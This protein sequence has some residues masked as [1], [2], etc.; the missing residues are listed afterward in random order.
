VTL[1]YSAATP[2]DLER[3]QAAFERHNY[4]AALETLDRYL[5]TGP[6]EVDALEAQVLRSQCR[7]KLGDWEKGVQ[8]L[9]DLLAA[10]PELD[11]RADLHE[12]L[13]EVGLQQFNYKRL[14]IE[15]YSA[16]AKFRLEAGD[17]QGAAEALLKQAEGYVQFDDWK[18]LRSFDG[19]QP[20]DWSASRRLQRRYAI[21]CLDRAVELVADTDLAAQATFRKGQLHHREL[22]IDDQ[23]VDTAIA[24]FTGL[25]ERWPAAPQAAEALYDL[26]Q[27]YEGFKQDYVKAVEAYQRLVES[28]SKSDFARRA[29]RQIE[30]IVSPVI[31]LYVEGPVLPGPPGRVHYRCR[32]VPTLTLNAYRVDLFDLIRRIDSL[33]DLSK[34]KPSMQ[35]AATWSLTLPDRGEHKFLFSGQDAL[36]P[37]V[38]PASEPGAYVILAQDADRKVRAETMMIVSRLACLTKGARSATLLLAADARSG[39]PAAG[40]EVLLQRRLDRDR[41]EYATGRTDDAGRYRYVNAAD[42]AAGNVG[43]SSLVL[44]RDGEHFAACPSFFSWYWWGYGQPYRAYSFTERPV[45]RP[46]QTVHFKSVLRSY[47]RGA[48]ENAPDRRLEVQVFNP[49]GEVVQKM[50]LQTNAEGSA[51]G[52][53]RLPDGAPLGVYR[54]NVTVDGHNL[55]GDG[56]AVFRIEEYR[57]PE[58]E[59]TVKADRPDCRIGQEVAVRIEARY[60]F[61]EPVA[62]AQV[63]ANVFRSRFRPLFRW[64]GR[65]PWFLEDFAPESGQWYRKTILPPGP[66]SGYEERELVGT[67]NLTTDDR[68]LA[69]IQLETKPFEADPQADLRYDIEAEATDASRR[70]I[71]GSG[72]IKVT[73]AP[74]TISIRPQR[75]VYQ[76]GDSVRLDIEARGPN[77]DP[78]GF[79]G[80]VRVHRLVSRAEEKQQSD[81]S[82]ASADSEV[83][84]YEPGDKVFEQAVEVG[85]TGNAQAQWVTDEEGP[86]RV[87]VQTHT[88]AGAVTGSCDLWIAQQGGRFAHYAYRDVELIADRLSYSVGETARVLVNTRFDSCYVLV[89]A[90]ADDL[91]DERLVFVKGGTQVVELLIR[92]SHVPN[93]ELTASVL[94][95][96]HVYQDQ[97]PVVVPPV[98]RFL[99]VSVQTPAESFHPRDKIDL[100]VRTAD[101]TGAAAPAEVALMMVDASIYY[102]QP[103]FREPIEKFF[104]G[105]KRPHQVQTQTSFDLGNANYGIVR[106]AGRGDP[107]GVEYAAAAPMAMKSMAA[108]EGLLDAAAPAPPDSFATAEIRKDFPD[109]V[110][111]SAHVTTDADGQ[112]SVPVTLPDTLTTWRIHAIAIDRQTRVGQAAHDIVTRKEIIA[113]LQAPRFLVEGDEPVLTVIAHNYLDEPKAV[114]I[115]L[116][117]TSEIELGAA[118]VNG[119]PPSRD[120]QVAQTP[121]AVIVTIPPQGEAAVDFPARALIAGRAQLTATAAADVDA[122]ALQITLP[123]VTYGADRFVAESGSLRQDDEATARTV[124]LT[125]PE[126][127]AP[128]SQ[129]LEIHLNP[130]MAAV[131]IDALPYLLDYPYG[132]TEQTMSRFLPAVVTRRTLQQLGIDLAAVRRKLEEQGGPAA[133]AVPDRFR[134][135]PVFN[136]ALMND[137]IRVGLQRLGELQNADGGWGW[138]GGGSSN[139]YMTAYVVYGLSEAVTAD[140]AFDHSMLDRGVAFL[141]GRAVSTEAAARYAWSADDDNVR[142]WM[143]Y[144]LSSA[145]AALLRNADLSTLVDR[146]YADRDGL[147]DYSRALLLMVLHR[148]G[149]PERTKVLVE[150]L[151]NTVQ[152]DEKLGTASWGRQQGYRYWYDNALEATS[153]VL[154]A[155]VQVDRNHPYVPKAVNWLVRN[156]RGSRW[157]ST[158][159]TAMAVYALADYLAASGELDAD[160]TVGVTIDGRIERTFRITPENA[161]TFDTAIVVSPK[162]LPPGQHRVELTRSGRGNLYYGVYLTYFTRQDPIEPAAHEVSVIRTYT[163]L[164]PRQVTRTRAIYDPQQDKTVD[165]TYTALDYD[166]APIA[167]G[168]AVA[169]G[170]LIEVQLTVEASNN[171]EYL[172]FEDPKPAGCEPTE[173]RSGSQAGQGPCEAVELRD[174]KT[175]FFASYLPQG[176]HELVYRLRCETPGL[177]HALPARAEAM[178]SP[179]VRANSASDRLRIGER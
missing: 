41:F 136:D 78:V 63:T 27:L 104:Y 127:I 39:A 38:L 3:A 146:I 107:M 87:I 89:T 54:M 110:L 108:R 101:S 17:L 165:E 171:Y 115:S 141:Q 143:L 19:P 142:V 34:W 22:R 36:E 68:G 145:D 2:P 65:W 1:V 150:N 37:T 118:L 109:T 13:G 179:F 138:W 16:L 79:Q 96:N 50:D 42:A 12:I 135:N 100:K 170:D 113:R 24:V 56:D 134:G 149:D 116:Q 31:E 43:G 55:G 148:L 172:V 130:S 94:R 35:P 11:S 46:D 73:H 20:D 10:H 76:P 120:L 177:F 114:R 71:T 49:R 162:N 123:V 178:Y 28:Q 129:L 83:G 97:I 173:L 147:T 131:M 57:K 26:G 82:G 23:D 111:W 161:L 176:R 4:K 93:F 33:Y 88:D 21:E 117:T 98:D 80:T 152:V 167:E 90:E 132:C 81:D 53:L 64:P 62:G 122:D 153:M 103:E 84:R 18:H 156:R 154:R 77:D 25:V 125:I 15:H 51:S 14:A 92:P 32:N 160:L 163:R 85:A 58:F 119:Q 44:V 75:Y 48:Y 61:G 164:I 155:L 102:I 9:E 106:R 86:F 99:D 52:E 168:E 158:K 174:Q 133:G 95:D 169:S 69:V 60:Y 45:Y 126:E 121:G 166:R 159:D 47:D 151:D 29:A 91:L 66:W 124:A 137:M 105:R 157:F 139:P 40:A 67:Y 8:E 59:V 5:E 30:Q 112:A 140:V 144:A 128:D 74:F 175:A 7:I 72:T 70:V 6:A